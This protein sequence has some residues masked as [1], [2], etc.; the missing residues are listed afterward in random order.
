M[1]RGP[2]QVP[3]P[4]RGLLEQWEPLAIVNVSVQYSVI[5]AWNR[6]VK[7]SRFDVGSIRTL[8]MF[9]ENISNQGFTGHEPCAWRLAPGL[10]EEAGCGGDGAGMGSLLP[11]C[12]SFACGSRPCDGS[13]DPQSPPAAMWEVGPPRLGYTGAPRTSRIVSG[14]LWGSQALSWMGAAGLLHLKGEK[15]PS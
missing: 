2:P 10:R 1:P 11:R 14:Q 5:R 8:N 7:H 6:F 13:M 4:D 15:T 12:V 9:I 3:V